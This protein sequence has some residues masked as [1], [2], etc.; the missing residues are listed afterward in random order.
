[1][2]GLA[3]MGAQPQE[4]VPTTEDGRSAGNTTISEDVVSVPVE[5]EL[6]GGFQSSKVV[7]GVRG[8][9]A[10]VASVSLRLRPLALKGGG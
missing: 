9:D 3:Q 5:K 6:A 2:V 8:V 1:M 10:G 4:G 7:N